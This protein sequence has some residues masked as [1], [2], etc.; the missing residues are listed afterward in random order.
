MYFDYPDL[1]KLTI[2]V[3]LFMLCEN[4]NKRVRNTAWPIV[5]VWTECPFIDVVRRHYMV[6]E[7]NQN[8]GSVKTAVAI[9]F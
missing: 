8:Y 4:R 7:V 9:K 3:P 1:V 5:D 6:S 2:C